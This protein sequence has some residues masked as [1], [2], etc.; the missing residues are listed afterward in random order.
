MKN[1]IIKELTVHVVSVDYEQVG[2]W[3]VNYPVAVITPDIF[4]NRKFSKVFFEITDL[5]FTPNDIKAKTDVILY[6]TVADYFDKEGRLHV[7]EYK[8]TK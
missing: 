4:K 3:G 8:Y 7:A 6:L 2:T 5:N 1:Y